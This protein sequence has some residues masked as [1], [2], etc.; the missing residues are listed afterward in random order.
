M[1]NNFDGDIL[2]DDVT[3]YLGFGRAAGG[4]SST[5]PRILTTDSDPNG[6]L[7]APQGSIALRSDTGEAVINKDGGTLWGS[8]STK[9]EYIRPT[10]PV[11]GD[12]PATIYVGDWSNDGGGVGTATGAGTLANPIDT[13]ANTALRIPTN[14]TVARTVLLADGHTENIDNILQFSNVNITG[15][16]KTLD[17]G[18]IDSVTTATEE[19]IELELDLGQTYVSGELVGRELRWTNG[20]AANRVGYIYESGAT[21]AGTTRV[22]V[23][24]DD[25]NTLRVPLPNNAV[26]IVEATSTFNLQA[27]TWIGDAATGQLTFTRMNFTGNQVLFCQDTE[28]I[29]FTYCILKIGRLQAGTGGAV[30]LLGSFLQNQG[31]PNRGMLSIRNGGRLFLFRGTVIHAGRSTTANAGIEL[32]A[33]SFTEH[34]GNNVVYGLGSDGLQIDGAIVFFAE[35][36]DSHDVLSFQGASVA[37]VRIDTRGNSGKS[38]VYLPN[39]LGTITDDYGILTGD[40]EGTAVRVA[41]SSSLISGLGTNVYS[42]DGG[43]TTS[44]TSGSGAFTTTIG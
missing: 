9:L 41:A 15:F 34:R 39:L 29:I 12:L 35:N 25:V 28:K 44:T 16:S 42:A 19:V 3:A 18:A 11:P 31:N 14:D 26:T 33:G 40:G 32:S 13:W 2:L 36:P 4:S 43:S 5:G 8:T 23:S 30:F 24:Q 22:L 7:I 21:A 17:S 20:P 38:T 27:S 37:G 6:V 1:S 10:A